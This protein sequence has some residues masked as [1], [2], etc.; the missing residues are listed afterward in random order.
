MSTTQN[1]IQEIKMVTT[2]L[3]AEYGHSAG[4]MLS[5]TY[6]SGTNQLHFEGE[7]RYIN[8]SLLHRAYFNL[9]RP[10]SPVQLSRTGRRW[11]AGR[12]IFPRSTTGA[13]RHS[14]CSAGRGTTRNTISSSSQTSRVRTC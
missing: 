14:F 4:G 6:K 13:T 9:L 7:D 1:A 10:T 8:N 11:S 2:V 5:A 12:F 3:P